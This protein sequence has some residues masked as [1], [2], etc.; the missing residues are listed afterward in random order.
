MLCCPFGLVL[1]LKD[2]RSSWSQEILVKFEFEYRMT[3]SLRL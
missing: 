2:K 3:C 1:T